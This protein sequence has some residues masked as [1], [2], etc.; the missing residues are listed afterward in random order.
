MKFEIIDDGY[1]IF[2]NPSIFGDI[3]WEEKEVVIDRV[4]SFFRRILEC[5]PISL[6]GFYKISVYPSSVGIIMKVI[7]IDNYSYDDKKLDFRIVVYLNKKIYFKTDD[8]YA[9]SRFDN[10]YY[11]DD[12]YYVLV[13]DID[14]NFIYLSEFGSLVVMN[15]DLSIKVLK[16]D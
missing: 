8:F 15:D 14:I 7:L 5:Y 12:F 3:D 6:E 16:K 1:L 11:D 4:T 13:D 10:I 9:V 2:I